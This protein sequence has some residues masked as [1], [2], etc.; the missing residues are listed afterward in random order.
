MRLCGLYSIGD[1]IF[2]ILLSNKGIFGLLLEL[3][4]VL[5][6]NIVNV[7][8]LCICFMVDNVVGDFFNI[9][10]SINFM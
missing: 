2:V 4:R 7:D 6:L 5:G 9:Y 10:I 1:E 3:G 8:E